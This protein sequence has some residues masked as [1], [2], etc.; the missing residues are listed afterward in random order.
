MSIDFVLADVNGA[1]VPMVIKD[2]GLEGDGREVTLDGLE[3]LYCQLRL[4]STLCVKVER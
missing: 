1:D 4:D 3:L 2:C